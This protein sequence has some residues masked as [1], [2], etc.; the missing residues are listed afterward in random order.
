[1]SCVHDTLQSYNRDDDAWGATNTKTAQKTFAQRL[2]GVLGRIKAAIRRA[3]VDDDIFDIKGRAASEETADTLAVDDPDPFETDDST[4]K[5]I[6]F[7]A[8]LREQLNNEYLE[9]VGRD[10]NQWVRKAYAE[11]IRNV[12]RQLS[13]LDV[14]FQ[15]PDMDELLGR[16][17]HT[18]ALQEL[19]TRTYENLQSVTDDVVDEVRDTLLEGFREGENPNKI[20][21]KMNARIDSVGKWRSTMIARSEVL[22]AHSEGTLT[23]VDEV[24]EGREDSA[25]VSHGV[26]M[27]AKDDRVCAFCQAIDGVAMTTDEMRDNQVSV[28]GALTDEAGFVGGSFRLKP[29]AHPN[30]R[31]AI[32]VQ[33]GTEDVDAELDDRLPDEIEVAQ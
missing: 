30:G 3:V 14:A 23:R 28:T 27:T 10:K 26:W 1:M 33:I 24:N 18:R 17:L 16:P 15:R 25:L 32:Q 9:V 7:V 11:G 5:V 20:A 31:C 2:R 29:P 4:K 19:Y 13:D 12:H 6:G 22:N 21:K 8:W